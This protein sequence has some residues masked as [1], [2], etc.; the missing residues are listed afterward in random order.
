MPQTGS[1]VFTFR[2]KLDSEVKLDA[3]SGDCRDTAVLR[4]AHSPNPSYRLRSDKLGGGN[5]T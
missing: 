3:V 2:V 5:W 4:L 1:K